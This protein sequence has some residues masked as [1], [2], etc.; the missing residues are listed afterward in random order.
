MGFL[1]TLMKMTAKPTQRDEE[2]PEL[3]Y[4]WYLLGGAKV[5]AD[6][7]RQ[8]KEGIPFA[9]K[10]LELI[11][12]D[13]Q[14]RDPWIVGT[15]TDPE[16]IHKTIQSQ[17]KDYEK[18]RGNQTIGDLAGRYEEDITKYLEDNSK[19]ALEELGKFSDQRYSDIQ[20]ELEK[21][22]YIINGKKHGRSTD[23]EVEKAKKSIE[24]YE[25]VV[26]TISLLEG[27]HYRRFG[28]RVEEEVTRDSL[29]SLYAPVEE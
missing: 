22:N 20:E 12:E 25:K 13:A 18:Y 10:S 16:V 6:Y 1:K 27:L 19:T 14:V 29:R 8:G 28:A 3:N 11:L 24:K 21:L 26:A 7:L 17:L 9:R 5:A 15:V 23:K 4:D 2:L